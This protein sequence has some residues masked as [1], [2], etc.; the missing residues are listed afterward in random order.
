MSVSI[1]PATAAD[2]PLMRALAEANP[3]L[4][5]HTGYTYWVIGHVGEG[6]SFVAERDGDAVGFVA[7]VPGA[8][9]TETA[10]IWQ[11]CVDATARGAGLGRLLV[12]AARDAAVQRGLARME[13]SISTD[14]AASRALFTSVFGE[15]LVAHGTAGTPEH[16]EDLFVADIR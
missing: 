15:P 2:A 8:L 9:A 4:D 10:L 13:F 11:V 14:N 6:L 5:V 16:P 1:R 12:G 3:P 7:V